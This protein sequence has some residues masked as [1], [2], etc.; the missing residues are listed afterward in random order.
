[1]FLTCHPSEMASV[2]IADSMLTVLT[3]C[4]QVNQY[5][6]NS[7]GFSGATGHFTQ[8]VW[9]STRRMGCARADACSWRTF[10]C[11]Y[12]PPGEQQLL[13][14][15]GSELNSGV[16]HVQFWKRLAAASVCIQWS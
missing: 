16:P 14:L 3:D 8:L 11:Q 1:V 7:P 6:Y 13:F 5:S 4:P 9:S 10:V 15:F 2:Y 12:S